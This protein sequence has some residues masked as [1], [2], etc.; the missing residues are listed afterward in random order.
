MKYLKFFLPTLG[1][2]WII[3]LLSIAGQ[4]LAG[5]ILM[6]FA[7]KY[8]DVTWLNLT[9]PYVL[10]FA[11]PFI[12]IWIAG[13]NCSRENDVTGVV[14]SVKIEEPSFGRLHPL[15][16]FF[17]ITVSAYA[18]M[19]AEDPFNIWMPAPEW[20]VQLMEKITADGDF[21][22]T[23]VTVAVLA[24]VLE[25]FFCRGIIC[26]GLLFHYKSPWPAILWSAVIFAVMHL[27]PWQGI[28]AFLLGAWYGWIYYRTRSLKATIFL[29]FINN[30]SIVVLSH[31]VPAF[32][33]TERMSDF[34]ASMDLYWLAVALSA[35]LFVIANL[36]LLNRFL[37]HRTNNV[38]ENEQ[39]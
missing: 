6:P 31:L 35:A 28:A 29:H 30:G 12:Y 16:F 39:A 17:T 18:I 32:K 20:F 33:E 22:W 2:S 10:A 24:P 19:L 7:Y 21:F 34:F 9:V 13:R 23:F 25:E 11:L 5:F 3:L 8:P 38:I 37:T 1:Q 4:L 27:N 15:L 36:L 14:P 26:R